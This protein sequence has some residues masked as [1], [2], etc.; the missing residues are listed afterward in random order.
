MVLTPHPPRPDAALL[1]PFAHAAPRL[2]AD[3]GGDTRSEKEKLLAALSEL[4][5]RVHTRLST[6]IMPT[7]NVRCGPSLSCF[8]SVSVL[9]PLPTLP[10]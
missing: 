10:V 5:A 3:G 1:E 2:C 9:P 8:V 6:E 7:L 4:R